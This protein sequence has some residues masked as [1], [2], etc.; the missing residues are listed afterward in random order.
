VAE[1]FDLAIRMGALPDDATLAA[2]PVMISTWGLFASASYSLLRGFPEQPDDLFRHDLLS[3][4]RAVNGLARWTLNRGKTVWERDVPV[5]MRANSPELLSRLAV[6][7][8]GI[9]TCTEEFAAPHVK[10]GELV[11]ILPEWS[12]PQVTG[13]AVFP[14]RRLMPAKT[15]AFL[16]ML[17]ANFN[18]AR[19]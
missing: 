18:A 1:G 8:L 10:R 12:F 13:W 11:R 16:D 14:G 9:A 17:E 19:A 3:L 6:A 4:P 15:R 7:S 2:R 5:K